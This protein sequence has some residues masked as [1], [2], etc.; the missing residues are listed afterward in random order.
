MHHF[1]IQCAAFIARTR[2]RCHRV[3]FQTIAIKEEE[4]SL[5]EN[6][7]ENGSITHAVLREEPGS[8]HDYRY[9]NVPWVH[10]TEVSSAHYFA[11]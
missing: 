2:T 6:I 11:H 3:H 1:T 8:V 5:S 7:C 9:M 10:G 4:E